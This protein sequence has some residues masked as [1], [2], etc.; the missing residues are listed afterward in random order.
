[1]TKQSP[2][3][4]RTARRSSTRD[5]RRRA[6]DRIDVRGGA[7]TLVIAAARARTPRVSPDGRWVVFW[8]GLPVW[9]RRPYSPGAIRALAVNVDIWRIPLETNGAVRPAPLEKVTD[10]AAV[11]QLMNG[12]RDGTVTV[13][14]SA[15]TKRD[16]VWSRD[17]RTGREAT[18]R[19]RDCETSRRASRSAASSRAEAARCFRGDRQ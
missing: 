7:P 8:T 5:A 1:M 4:A 6:I 17:M 10:D 2:H 16:E 3:S 9:W 12:T 19:S 15:R 18:T 11:D 13:F 14:I